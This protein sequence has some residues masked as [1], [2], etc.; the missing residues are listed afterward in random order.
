MSLLILWACGKVCRK[1]LQAHLV[2]L[3]RFMVL[4]G[5]V[6]YTLKSGPSTSKKIATPFV[7]VARNQTH[8]VSKVCLP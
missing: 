1:Q 6:F 3:L 7:T 4:H 8:R 5:H 2:S